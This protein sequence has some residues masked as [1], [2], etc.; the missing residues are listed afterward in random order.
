MRTF[1]TLIS[2]FETANKVCS[3]FYLLYYIIK[4]FIEQ[5]NNFTKNPEAE[6][7]QKRIKLQ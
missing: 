3:K 4:S 7:R 1:G 5:F 6:N 2:T